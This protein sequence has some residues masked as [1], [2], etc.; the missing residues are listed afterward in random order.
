MTNKTNTFTLN[1]KW[2]L[3]IAKE[4]NNSN[5]KLINKEIN[6]IL[7]SEEFPPFTP[8]W[9]ATYQKT[10]VQKLKNT[11]S[12]WNLT[13][14]CKAV[15]GI[16]EWISEENWVKIIRIKS[17]FENIPFLAET[18]WYK[19][20]VAKTLINE[21]KKN[22]IDVIETPE[23][24][25]EIFLYYIYNI[26]TLNKNENKKIALRLH[27]PLFLT[28]KLNNLKFS[29]KNSI[30]IFM[31]KFL[32]N[33]IETVTAC[34]Q[35]LVDKM[36]EIH[37]MKENIKII[38]NPWNDFIF[39]KEKDYDDIYTIREE[40]KTNILFAWSLEYRKG[41]DYFCKSMK[42]ILDNNPNTK[43]ILSGKY[44]ESANANS[45]LSKNEVLS[46]FNVKD[47][48]RIQF[49]WL[50]PYEKMPHVYKHVDIC[51]FP[52][53]YDNYP[54]VV[55]ESLLMWK[56]VIGSKNTWITESVK[57]GIIYINPQDINSI[58]NETQK[59]LDNPIEREKMWNLWHEVVKWL[60]E[61][62]IKQFITYYD[63]VKNNNTP[64]NKTNN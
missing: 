40:W 7:V 27:T 14:I 38:H 26:L 6:L 53:I 17:Y 45:K 29:I 36:N 47:K 62:N 20:K 35:S 3:P 42:N 64:F 34:S 41:I 10:L 50:I 61:E 22:W 13:V 39:Q 59:L 54:W 15:W 2:L 48:N 57:K 25:Q 33:N 49:L 19:A 21:R 44:W 28:K 5:Y 58:I 56:A 4:K 32:I 30:N 18:I 37:P 55:I 12:F 31:E 9:I 23:W 60:N 24:N 52:S 11:W 43:I 8:G 63:K 16:K 1:K 51:I 46:F